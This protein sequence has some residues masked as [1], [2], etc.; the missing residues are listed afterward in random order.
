MKAQ[1]TLT[2]SEGKRLIAK[3]IANLPEVQQALREGKIL[4]KGGTT[5]SAVAEELAGIALRISGRITPR[6]T[7]A[8][9]EQ[10][11]APHTVLL[12][13]GLWRNVDAE[14]EEAVL[15]MAPSDVAVCG[16]NLIDASGRAAIMAGSPLGGKP[17]KVLAALEAEGITT[18]I[19]AG[20]E[21]LSPCSI[22][23]AIAAAGRRDTS[24]SMG[25]AVGL[26]PVPGRVITEVTAITLLAPVKATVIGRGGIDGAEGSTTLAVEGE[27]ENVERLWE[28]VLALKGARTSGAEGSLVECRRGGPNCQLHVGCIYGGKANH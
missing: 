13:R 9:R 25:M 11:P 18:I 5:V 3:A 4:L 21:K 27:A 7:R 22:T 8:G 16:A 10:L 28:L 15:G 24:R 20:L 19:A 23:E 14:L 6:G 26:I 12:E 2:V 17:G 1:I